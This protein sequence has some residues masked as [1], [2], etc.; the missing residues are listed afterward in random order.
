MVAIPAYCSSCNRGFSSSFEIVSGTATYSGNR[1]QCPYCGNLAEL[2]DGEMAAKGGTLTILKGGANTAR[3]LVKLAESARDAGN[4]NK[5]IEEF[6]EVAEKID[7]AIGLLAKKLGENCG[8]NKP[9][10]KWWLVIAAGL[11]VAA[12]SCDVNINIDVDVNQLAA[13]LLKQ[14]PS[15]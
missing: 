4:Q 12:S 5:T 15:Q 11:T 1:A 9:T 10:K 2:V 13:Q 6:V 8:T 3:L 7:P 14:S